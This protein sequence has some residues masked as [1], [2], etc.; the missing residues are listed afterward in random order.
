MSC[1]SCKYLNENKKS[2]GAVSGCC[3]YCS[4]CKDYVNGS[5]S[6]C[7]NYET[8]GRSSYI[9]G[10]IYEE[11]E[12]YYNDLTSNFVYLV[13]LLVMVILAIIVNIF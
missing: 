4:K 11:G 3:Y 7:D 8:S 1:S 2:K 6:S 5:N 10:K 9:C 12:G 13:V